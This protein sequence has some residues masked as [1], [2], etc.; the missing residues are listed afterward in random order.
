[1]TD[2]ADLDA[3]VDSLTLAEQVALVSGADFWSVPGVPRLGLGSLVVTDGPN[4]ARGGGGLIGNTPSASFPVGVALGATWDPAL[5]E[6]IGAALALE[7]RDKGAHVLLAPTINLQRG[8][9]NGRN[10]E[11]YS[12][13]PVLTGR[14]AVGYVRGL[15]GGGVGATLKHFVGNE[16]E[17][18]RTTNSSDIDERTLRELYLVPFEM[19][20]KE[21]R[22]WAVMTS[23]NRLNGT[24]TSEHDWLLA[25]VL[26]SEWGFDG[27]V[28]SDWFG[29]N[30]TAPSVNAGL[31]LEMPG[32]TRDRGPKLVAAVEA[33]EVSAETLRARALAVLRL[34]A[35]TGAM[36]A[37]GPRI[38]LS[39]E[40]P[41]VRALVR[42]AGA[43]GAVL[44]KNDGALPLATGTRVALIGPNAKVARTMGGGSAQLVA[45]RAVSPWE[46]LA[47]ILGDAN[48]SFA[49]GADN[50]RCVPTII[51]PLEAE[52][53]QN[54]DFSGGPVH[55]ST[56]DAATAF[57]IG[58][59]PEGA[60]DATRPYALRLTGR[61]VAQ[62][63]GPHLAGLHSAGH[64]RL[65]VDGRLVVDCATG[66]APGSTFFEMGCD[67]RRGTVDLV[68]G[69]DVEIVIDFRSAPT[70][71]LG[72]QG[73]HA[74]L[75]LPSGTAEIAEAVR[76][77]A[78]ADVAVLCVGRLADWDTEGTDLPDLRLPGM[79]DALIA[80]VAAAAK[81]TV[82]VLQTGGPVEMPWIDA[83]D[84]VLQA[85][86]PGQEAGHAIADVLTGRAEPGGRLPQ[87]FPARTGDQPTQGSGAAV[88]PGEEGHVVYAEGLL[89]GQRHHDRTG[90]APLFPLGHGLTWTDFALSD[91]RAD[92]A[93]VRLRVTNI[94]ERTGTA[95]VQVYAGR[96][97]APPD[98]P[99]RK[100]AAFGRA[101]LEPG[102]AR[103][104]LL[105]LPPRTFARW[106]D[107]GWR[108]DA[109]EWRIE[110][111]LS[112]GDL[113]AAAVV[114]VAAALN[115]P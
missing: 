19:A 52:W 80:A 69:Q 26:R 13:D 63:T 112:A 75:S 3:L 36:Q 42:R 34:M 113:Q 70:R 99:V 20:V 66:W 45:H 5:L 21:G 33:G 73:F 101:R 7:V 91:L 105:D 102:E 89:I 8:G 93:T 58:A 11:C 51:G 71:R 50:F 17:I 1:M 27:L 40:R 64:A 54:H 4:G 25:Q 78:R 16:S 59:R 87:V 92:A 44:L 97:D 65:F 104:L 79:Q 31:D 37:T 2:T 28:M 38:E 82:V 109:A 106:T 85:W 86:Y 10:F 53:F 72:L 74:G 84:A 88:Y 29:S 48:L 115:G 114:T 94:G 95:V 55:R 12:E 81:R 56:F 22:A 32:P 57:L 111:G 103:E 77:A 14:L 23:Y 47:G 43:A 49:T 68:A 60:V 110:A 30:S 9:Q 18:R 100:L 83:V 67:E 15:Q 76:V 24:Y 41:A 39:N 61:F 108:T 35:R 46:G 90:I 62:A 6:E 107:Q 96:V 98:E